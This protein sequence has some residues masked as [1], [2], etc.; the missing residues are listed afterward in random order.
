MMFEA[1]VSVWA[2]AGADGAGAV[3]VALDEHAT[4]AGMAGDDDEPAMG[5]QNAVGFGEHRGQI[6][7]VG[8]RQ[9]RGDGVEAVVGERELIGFSDHSVFPASSGKADLRW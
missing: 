3:G 1:L 9:N 5:P 7:K 6:V 2:V 4:K 8:G